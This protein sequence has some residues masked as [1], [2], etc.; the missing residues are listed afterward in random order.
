MTSHTRDPR[1]NAVQS[2]CRIR[3]A[4]NSLQSGIARRPVR[5]TTHKSAYA[6]R[7]G[8]KGGFRS[9]SLAMASRGRRESD[10]P[11]QEDDVTGTASSDS[12]MTLDR[13]FDA[14]RTHKTNN[15]I[16]HNE[17]QYYIHSSPWERDMST[18]PENYLPSSLRHY[19][20]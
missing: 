11:D 20:T 7:R 10:T 4:C 8:H 5:S 13:P 12:N 3:R 9:A 1:V 17:L 18:D 16:N 15:M 2:P 14:N 6:P 19:E